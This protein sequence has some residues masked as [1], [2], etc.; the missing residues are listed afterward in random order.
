MRLVQ[1]SATPIA[2]MA[3]P[4]QIQTQ[5]EI[6]VSWLTSKTAPPTIDAAAAVMNRRG[7]REFL[8]ARV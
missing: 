3:T 6:G 8:I 2:S 1:S 7:H 5:G 4:N